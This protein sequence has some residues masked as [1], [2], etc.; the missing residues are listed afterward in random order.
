MISPVSYSLFINI[1]LE[2]IVLS[3][4]DQ[5]IVIPR[6][7]LEMNLPK[8]L[9]DYFSKQ[10]KSISEFSVYVLNG[11]GSFTN[12][13]IGCLC[14]NML[15]ELME[16]QGKKIH[17]YHQDKKNLYRILSQKGFLVSTGIMY[18]GQRKNFWVG[19]L[20]SDTMQLKAVDKTNASG[21][22]LG[23]NFWIDSQG[24][25]LNISSAHHLDFRHQEGGLQVIWNNQVFA[26]PREQLGF[27]EVDKLMPN[28]IL[29]PN[30]SV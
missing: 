27:E 30:I 17:L 7:D 19:D 29:E 15:K 24:E 22:F 4:D 12:L 2:N 1:S 13:R 6:G 5:Y 20:Q 8:A 25:S 21:F 23:K 16:I 18:I 11:P 9:Y 28:Y 14:V 26:A 10:D 3:S